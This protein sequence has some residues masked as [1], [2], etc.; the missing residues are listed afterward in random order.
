M[1]PS[2]SVQNHDFQTHKFHI[3]HKIL[4]YYRTLNF[5]ISHTLHAHLM[6]SM[7]TSLHTHASKDAR[8]HART[9][10]FILYIFPVSSTIRLDTV[11][12]HG[13]DTYI[14]IQTK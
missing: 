2:Q 10:I 12:I 6:L 13:S 9:H 7:S 8:T 11:Q 3:Y 1:W 4:V 14:R 5:E